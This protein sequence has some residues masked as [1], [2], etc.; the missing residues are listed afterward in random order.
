MR[1]KTGWPE[2]RQHFI[3]W[4]SRK[5]M[6]LWLTADRPAPHDPIPRPPDPATPEAYWFDTPLRISW[7]EYNLS[8]TEFLADSFPQAE[9]Q[10]GPGS[11]A[12][13]LG[14]EPQVDWN[15][16]WYL[17]CIG[18]PETYGPITLNPEK[19]RW[20]E[21]HLRTLDE[22]L[23][24]SDGRWLAGIPDLIENLDTLAALR[25]DKALFFDLVERPDWVYERL[26]EINQAFFQAYDIFFERCRM[27]NKE[28]AGGSV[29]QAFNLWGPGKVA[30]VQCDIS[31]SL[32]PRMFR[33]FALPHLEAQCRW[34]DH[35]LYHLDGTTCLQH[36]DALLETEVIDAIEWTPQALSQP[37]GGDPHWYDLYRRIKSA[38]KGVQVVGVKA[39]EVVPLLDAIGPQGTYVMVDGNVSMDAAEVILKAIEP[40]RIA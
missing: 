19:N 7:S 11:L 15:T 33:R 2:T 5:G 35:S 13:F 36:L 29:F 28:I 12:T 14:A 10:L 18:D 9:V 31:A 20:L 16:V 23:R 25:G 26:G 24:R 34:L 39:E 3:D 1:Y 6:V 27:G 8:R 30:K 38:G 4:W 17:P 37:N 21:M 40:F 32:S 22:A